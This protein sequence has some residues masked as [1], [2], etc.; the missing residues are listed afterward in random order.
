[1]MEYPRASYSKVNINLASEGSGE[2]AVMGIRGRAS[3]SRGSP[4]WSYDLQM[5][6]VARP[7][8]FSR[9]GGR[10]VN[11][12]TLYPSS[13]LLPALTFG[14]ILLEARGHRIR[15]M[16]FIRA[17]ALAERRAKWKTPGTGL[18]NM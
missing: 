3:L 18:A 16:W 6:D 7:L 15:L 13:N 11:N 17:A 10:R 2:G 9:E 1:M 12:L 14:Q 4:L 8:V 5:K